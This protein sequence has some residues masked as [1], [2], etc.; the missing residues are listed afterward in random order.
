MRDILS[1]YCGVGAGNTSILDR[2]SKEKH[3]D[4]LSHLFRIG[5]RKPLLIVV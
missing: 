2:I 3:A 1:M 4:I 5:S